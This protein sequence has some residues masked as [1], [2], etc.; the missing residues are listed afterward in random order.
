MSNLYK[1]SVIVAA[2]VATTVLTTYLWSSRPDE[3]TWEG[4]YAAHVARCK[5]CS[6]ESQGPAPLC[7]EAFDKFVE[8]L[9]AE[10]PTIAPQNPPNVEPAPPIPDTPYITP[11]DKYE[12]P[13]KPGL[14]VVSSCPAGGCPP[15]P[16]SSG[17]TRRTLNWRRR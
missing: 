3:T 12:P 1:I 7:T 13:T 15:T 6:D 14:A 5:T 8:M 2:A 16:Q 4:W 9:E 10:K 17:V 11:P